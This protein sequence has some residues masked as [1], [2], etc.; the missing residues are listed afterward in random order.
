MSVP[1]RHNNINDSRIPPRPLPLAR[2]RT[3]RLGE[4]LL[5]DPRPASGAGRPQAD[6]QVLSL[7]APHSLQ[8]QAQTL[9]GAL[10]RVA[11]VTRARAVQEEVGRE[12][13]VVQQREQLAPEERR[14]VELVRLV[15]DGD[16]ERL[17]AER[18]AGQVQKD[19][20]TGDDKQ[21]ARRVVLRVAPVYAQPRLPRVRDPRARPG[22]DG[23]RPLRPRCRARSVLRRRQRR[24]LLLPF[25]SARVAVDLH[26]DGGVH[27]QDEHDRH[28]D[29]RERVDARDRLQEVAVRDERHARGQSARA[30]DAR[31]PDGEGVEQQGDARHEGHDEGG[32]AA[33]AQLAA[34]QRL[35]DD[36]PALTR[37]ADDGPRRQEA[38]H[39]RE[40]VRQLTP[41]V[42]VE[43]VHLQHR[44]EVISEE[45]H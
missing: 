21:G 25:A 37:E 3:F 42:L 17:H 28:D 24:R 10:E 41:A 8:P 34:A 16:D 7:A 36:D 6:V 23:G 14:R 33:R 22:L 30:P 38:A 1:S 26:G 44:R 35:E 45:K 15:A 43:D 32:P 12:A 31:R 29:R 40:V 13:D 11:E 20:D 2:T 4:I 9:R 27:R 19:E 39:V 18:V 5:D